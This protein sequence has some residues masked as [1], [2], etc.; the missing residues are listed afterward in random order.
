VKRRSLIIYCNDTISG[1]LVGPLHDNEN[2]RDFMLS[3]LGGDWY[4]NEILSLKNPS[5]TLVLR[6]VNEFLIGADYTFIIFT[7]HGFINLDDGGRQY[8]ELANRSIG[9]SKLKTSAKRQTLI[10]DACRGYYSPEQELIKSF[11]EQ[12]ENFIGDPL[13][14]RAIFDR[15]VLRAE[16]GWTILYAANK[17]QSALD[18]AGGA[19]Y[20]LSLLKIAEIWEERDKTSN[21]LTL[22]STHDFAKTY[23]TENFDTLQ[24]PIINGEKRIVHFPFAVKSAT[25]YG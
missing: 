21:I 14:T 9:I 24:E 2:Y 8:I 22:K 10:V 16:E 1:E 11:S 7:G 3:K 12:Y 25:I 15:A 17:N 13:S 6:A 19:A 23:L 18:T 5:S 4:D 20:L